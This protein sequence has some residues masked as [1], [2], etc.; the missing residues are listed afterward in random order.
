MRKKKKG[1]ETELKAIK[2]SNRFKL[3]LIN[4]KIKCSFQ[5][6]RN[7]LVVYGNYRMV[8]FKINV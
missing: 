2:D 3:F 6:N 8:L 4:F 7:A 1:E 5:T